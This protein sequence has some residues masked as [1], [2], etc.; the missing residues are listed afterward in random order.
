MEALNACWLDTSNAELNRQIALSNNAPAA[1]PA[2]KA[3]SADVSLADAQT[4]LDIFKRAKGGAAELD[5]ARVIELITEHAKPIRVTERYVFEV[6]AKAAEITERQHSYFPLIVACLTARQ[7]VWLV[8][9]AGG[10]KT[11]LVS[12]AAK[13]AGLEYRCISVCAQTTKSDF[14]GF[15]DAHGIYRSTPFREAFETGKV[16]VLDEGDNGNANV[17][18]VMNAGMANGEM[19]FPDGIVKRHPDFCVVA[20]ANTFGQGAT[21]A[22]VGRNQ[23]D[24]A[25]LD[26]FFFITLPYDEGLEASFIGVSGVPSPAFSLSAGGTISAADWLDIVRKARSAAESNGIKTVISPRATLGGSKLASLGVGLNWLK[27]GFIAKSLDA[28]S[29]SRLF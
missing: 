5:E 11:T 4:I 26:R 16:F 19:A 29:A 12:Y 27:S 6:N 3:E 22:Y 25:T 15:I 21:S 13:A 10:G 18:A 9:P 23:L 2:A 24:A 28:N 20:C 1:K 17:L 7:H 14:L 8:G